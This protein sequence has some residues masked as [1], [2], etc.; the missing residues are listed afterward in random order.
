M[1]TRALLAL[2]TC[3]FGIMVGYTNCSPSA[4][5]SSGADPA[6]SSP[7]GNSGSGATV[8]STS[9]RPL[10]A[11]IGNGT[12][13]GTCLDAVNFK[14]TNVPIGVGASKAQWGGY[15][16]DFL[17]INTEISYFQDFQTSSPAIGFGGTQHD[18]TGSGGTTL[19]LQFYPGHASNNQAALTYKGSSS[20]PASGGA[21]CN[22]A[23]GFG[24]DHID[25]IATM[26][27]Y[28]DTV[29]ANLTCQKINSSVIT[30]ETI[31]YQLLNETLSFNGANISLKTGIS[32]LSIGI[33]NTTNQPV[34][35]I[36]FTDGSSFS[37][38]MKSKNVLSL[39]QYGKG[40]I[41]YIC[42]PKT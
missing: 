17:N 23:T 4:M 24:W 15:Q 12:Y 29:M 37:L 16:I 19:A 35:S 7:G 10:L 5:G 32:Q 34:M 42:R 2:I 40:S 1:R 30:I 31:P 8:D 11:S 36:T 14:V 21:V 26:E 3:S 28:M 22:S 27:P 20:S 38:Q 33:P 39:L 9:A 6:G 41:T 25:A 18:T 13:A